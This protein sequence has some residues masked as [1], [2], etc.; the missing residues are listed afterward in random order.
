[1]ETVKEKCL[2][3]KMKAELL[4]LVLQTPEE[5]AVWY[6]SRRGEASQESHFVYVEIQ[7]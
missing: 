6:V 1:M 2:E 4:E 3:Q 7:P 5:N